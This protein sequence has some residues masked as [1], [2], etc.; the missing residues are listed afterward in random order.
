MFV[1]SAVAPLWLDR[2]FSVVWMT[3]LFIVP[4]FCA[5]R[6]YP[7]TAAL[8]LLGVTLVAVPDWMGIP[9]VSPAIGGVAAVAFLAAWCLRLLLQRK[10]QYA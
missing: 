7:T 5:H 8:T 9:P 6:F 3:A 10:V 2:L 1:D 4:G